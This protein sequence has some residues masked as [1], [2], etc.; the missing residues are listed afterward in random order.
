MFGD[1]IHFASDIH[2]SLNYTSLSG[3]FWAKGRSS[4]GYMGLFATAYGEPLRIQYPVNYT[5]DELKQLGK[6]CVHAEAGPSLLN[7]EIVFYNED[8]V[9][10]N[11]IVEF[12]TDEED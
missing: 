7:D 10:L 9:L 3:S 2:K 11:Y 8:A 4:I 6:N 1:G 5:E 12:R